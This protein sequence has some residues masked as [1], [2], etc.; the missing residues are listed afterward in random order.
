MITTGV[1]RSQGSLRNGQY[2]LRVGAIKDLSTNEWVDLSKVRHYELHPNQQVLVRTYEAIAYEGRFKHKIIP[3]A[4]SIFLIGVNNVQISLDIVKPIELVI[5][6][7]FIDQTILLTYKMPFCGL[8][9]DIL[10]PW[11]PLQSV[12]QSYIVEKDR[13]GKT[14]NNQQGRL[15]ILGMIIAIL[16]SICVIL[17]LILL[18]QFAIFQEIGLQDLIVGSCIPVGIKL[19]NERYGL[20]GCIT[21]KPSNQKATNE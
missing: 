2:Y 13:G 19:L 6:N 21:R 10:N 8:L 11:E 18:H 16:F 9:F 15:C 7:S 4:N 5:K 3:L 20:W 14:S 12:E 17:I 1:N